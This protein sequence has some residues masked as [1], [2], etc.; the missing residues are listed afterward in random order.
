ML[1]LSLSVFC[2]KNLFPFF[3]CHDLEKANHPKND[4]VILETM[5]LKVIT[6]LMH[7]ETVVQTSLNCF[8]QICGDRFYFWVLKLNPGH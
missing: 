4:E 6:N 7:D 1:F 8:P 3:A 2:T 5:E